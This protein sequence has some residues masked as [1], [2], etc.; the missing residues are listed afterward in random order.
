MSSI[1]T[2]TR[3]GKVIGFQTNLGKD[4]TGKAQRKFFKHHGDAVAFIDSMKE[5]PIGTKLIMEHEKEL[6]MAMAECKKMGVTLHHVLDFFV[7][8]G[9]KKG[10]KPY[11]VLA[12]SFIADKSQT[13]RG[14]KYLQ[15]LKDRFDTFGEYI[16]SDVNVRTITSKQI[17][18]YVY[19]VRKELTPITK[20]DYIRSLSI[21]FNYAIRGG[22]LSTN[23]CVNVDRPMKKFAAPKVLSP[24]DLKILLNRCY[25]K[26]WYDRL[27]V[28]VLVSFCGIR[29]E[30]ACKL[31]WDNIDMVNK[32]VMVPA[33]IAKKARFR[34]NNISPNAMKWL[35][36]IYDGRRT[37]LIISDKA[38]RS[39]NSAVRFAH[40]GYTQ[41]CLRHSF[42]SYS[43]ENGMPL[44]DVVA[45]MGH[46]GSPNVIHT[47]YRNI[48]EP[49]TAKAWWSVVPPRTEK[50]S[51]VMRREMLEQIT[52][53]A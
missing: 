51:V 39:L 7:T 2:L 36:A 37:G 30:E 50:A 49:K 45:M 4:K 19:T 43:L 41:N 25:K 21:L 18:H 12:D 13:G 11:G 48:V 33:D 32:K 31:R 52:P 29:T 38:K 15:G 23:P 20:S 17:H 53:Q 35:E 22:F 27:T 44:A 3:D 47:H 16:G 9:P 40:I 14:V 46:N 24:E 6:K 42:C 28:F 34:R 1:S 5:D 26:G 8:H 10:D